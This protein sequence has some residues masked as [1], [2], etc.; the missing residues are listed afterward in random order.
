MAVSPPHAARAASSTRV[1]RF[2]LAGA[3]TLATGLATA[4]PVDVEAEHRRGVALRA[5]GHDVEALAVFRALYE[6]TG[7]GRAL[8]R[9]ALAEAAT[10][11]WIDAEEHLQ[12]AM[13]LTSDAWINANRASLD[14]AL[15]AAQTHLGS[16]RLRGAVEGAAS[17]I[18]GHPVTPRD[19][20]VRV[21]AGD[22]RVEVRVSGYE[23]FVRD[24]TVP[25]GTDST[26]LEVA[27]VPAAPAPP[28]PPPPPP[29]ERVVVTPPPPRPPPPPSRASPWRAV[30]VGAWAVGGAGLVLGVVGQVV[31]WG[32]ADKFDDAGCV[33]HGTSPTQ[34]SSTQCGQWYNLA[35]GWFTASTASF[36]AGGVLVASGTALWL[37]APRA[38]TTSSLSVRCAPRLDGVGVACEGTF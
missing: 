27:L 12:R 8:A 30:A 36:I 16:L 29:T 32:Y 28:P 4:Q 5:E 22:V 35:T 10:A 25:I 19:G 26:T 13:A 9:M 15:R 31:G 23:P 20:V 1:W 37:L 38:R 6:R 2:A 14:V 21:V 3:L 24:V 11:R 7:E 17:T 18:N 34:A 33:L